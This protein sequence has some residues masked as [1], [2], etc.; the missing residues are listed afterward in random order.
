VLDPVFR[1]ERCL[2]DERPLT[3]GG[4]LRDRSRELLSQDPDETTV[5]TA[6][7]DHGEVRVGLAASLLVLGLVA[8]TARGS[9]RDAVAPTIASPSPPGLLE[10]VKRSAGAVSSV[11]YVQTIV[12][13]G[14]AIKADKTIY[15][16]PPEYRV[17]LRVTLGGTTTSGSFY[18][19]RE[20]AFKCTAEPRCATESEDTARAQIERLALE[21]LILQH[22]SRLAQS[23]QGMRRLAGEDAYCYEVR[24]PADPR[25][26]LLGGVLC[27]TPS[28]IALFV[29]LDL[30]ETQISL[31]AQSVRDS[32]VSD[33]LRLPA[34]PTS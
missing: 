9:G 8:C 12:R 2:L 1:S 15:A 30:V 13:G 10:L 26:N 11:T 27:Y 25:L 14:Q 18:V 28:G 34:R 22:A 17:D 16:R 6:R 19:L 33:D 20:G 21:E 24:L 23:Y 32:V 29:R 31:E 7:R 3:K 4:S 5:V